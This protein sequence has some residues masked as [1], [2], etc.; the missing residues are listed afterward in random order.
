VGIEKAWPI[1]RTAN[2]ISSAQ[3]KEI[4]LI[5]AEV[6]GDL[7]E[8]AIDWVKKIRSRKIRVPS[9]EKKPIPVPSSLP[10][11][12]IGH[13]SRKIDGL[14]QRAILEGAKMTLAKGLK[15]EAKIFGECFLTKDM[16]IGMENFMR[17]GA[18]VNANFVHD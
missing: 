9:I 17:H 14:L 1:L 13:L 16:R 18:K 10:D 2:P 11:V 4:G 12:D 6:E 3:A 5:Q 7:I 8:K 15:L